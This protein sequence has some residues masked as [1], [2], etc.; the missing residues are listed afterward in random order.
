MKQFGVSTWYHDSKCY[1]VDRYMYFHLVSKERP[2]CWDVV[3]SLPLDFALPSYHVRL[4]HKQL[5]PWPF[6]DDSTTPP[7]FLLRRSDESGSDDEETD[8]ALKKL[9]S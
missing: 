9:E 1:P 2:T 4:E 7:P 3:R 8:P 5:V 6:A